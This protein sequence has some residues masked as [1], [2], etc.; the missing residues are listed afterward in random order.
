MHKHALKYAERGLAIFPCQVKGKE[1]VTGNGLNGASTD[2]DLI[3]HWWSQ[4]RDFN[5]GAR[6]GDGFFVVD[7]DMTDDKDGE[8][9]LA[10]LERKHGPMPPTVEVITGGGGRHMWFRVPSGRVIRNSTGKL[11][12][13]IDIRGEGGYVLVPPSVHASGRR[14]EFSVDSAGTLADAPTWLIEATAWPANAPKGKSEDEWH[15]TLTRDIPEGE[16]N[17]TLTSVAGKLL[18]HGL[19]MVLTHDIMASIS[20]ARCKPPLSHQEIETII[21]SIVRRDNGNG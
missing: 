11:G 14:Y 5:I 7:I 19:G 15:D 9:S 20:L 18:F 12:P 8:A 1:P 4:S 2:P 13:G 17:H 16:R 21:L 6:T 10:K 3:N